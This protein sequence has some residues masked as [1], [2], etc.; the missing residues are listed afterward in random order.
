MRS[1]LPSSAIEY[2]LIAPYAHSICSLVGVFMLFCTRARV[3]ASCIGVCVCVCGWI[4][5]CVHRTYVEELV[6]LLTPGVSSR[7]CGFNCLVG[8][9]CVYL[10]VV[11]LGMCFVPSVVIG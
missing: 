2:L 11:G 7:V 6:Y 10:A 1:A 8:L 3:P 5:L 9:R 4:S